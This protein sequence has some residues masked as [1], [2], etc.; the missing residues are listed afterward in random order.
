MAF[1]FISGPLW[2]GGGKAG[3]GAPD[4]KAKA[5]EA[6]NSVKAREKPKTVEK[7]SR[8]EHTVK[9]RGEKVDYV[10]TAGTLALKNKEEKPNASMFY[11]AYTRKD[12]DDL[13]DRPVVFCFNGGPGSS[14][15]W[16]H[17]G[18]FGPRL[19][20]LRGD[21]TK[22]VPPPYRVVANK[23]SILKEADLVF[24]DPVS[25]GFSRAGKGEDPKQFHGFNEDIKSVGEFIRLY[26][27]RNG[28]WSSPKF[29]AGE[30]YG[31]MRACGLAEHL[32]SRH[33]MYLNGIVLVSGVLDFKTLRLEEGN[34][35]GYIGYLPNYAAVA[36]FHGKLPKEKRRQSERLRRQVSEFALGPYAEALLL[37]ATL[38]EEKKTRVAKTLSRYTGL[39]E[40][41]IRQANLR[42]P[43]HQFRKELLRDQ[44]L[45]VG[46]FD[47]RVIGRDA[48][49][50]GAYPEYDPSFTVLYGPMA[51]ALNSYVR[52]ELNF[53]SDLPYEILSREVQPWS[54][55]SFT[56]RYVSVTKELSH[57]L[58]DNPA[59][60]VLVCFGRHDLATPHLA[61]RQS[62][63]HL[64]IDP[65]LRKNIAFEYYEGGHM[66]YT[67]PASLKK[68]N[69]DFVEFIEVATPDLP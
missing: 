60:K 3:D 15:V 48:D 57:A 41:L 12:V 66:M 30:S 62:L 51:G 67:V 32:Q 17:L 7:T 10:A 18:A 52:G 64:P 21:G 28:R 63:N 40:F 22:P 26:I 56:G 5:P 36:A 11:I 54:Y 50:A 24:I 29:L 25:T 61:M 42:V 59:L 46:R 38:P 13:S 34:D 55:K 27:T 31:A 49:K 2:A 65:G 53:D 68:L 23:H 16:L 19:V 39:P 45:T 43:G 1:L 44:G 8:T 6:G 9:I 58:R 33:G 14:S 20:D 4:A 35:A 37:G 69:L 47:G